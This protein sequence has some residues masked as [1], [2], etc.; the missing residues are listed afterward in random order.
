MKNI[1]IVIFAA[2]S[3]LISCSS[4]H[5]KLLIF[6]SN[7]IK[8]DEGQKNVTVTEGTTHHE[9]ELEWN[10][11]D[12]Q[13]L[14]AQTPKNKVTV[15][16]REDGYYILNLKPDTVV[17]SLQQVGTSERSSRISQEQMKKSLDSLQ[18]LVVGNTNGFTGKV[19][20]IPPGSS[21]RISD[22]VNSKVFGPYTPV[23]SA[24]DASPYAQVFKFYT[25][26]EA[27]EIIAKLI[28]AT[29]ADDEEESP[30]KK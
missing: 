28:Q 23:P 29:K 11:G 20:F 30:K 7:D 15:E 1:L 27:R 6:A 13:S 4:H 3:F 26:D 9:K 19:F 2:S 22:Q 18:R 16:I 8:V 10:N 12:P 5:K 17:G 14:S 21:A 25:N 24:F